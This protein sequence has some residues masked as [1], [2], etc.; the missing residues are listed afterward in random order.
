MKLI[1]QFGQ[2]LRYTVRGMR[3]N[4]LFTAMAV[5]SLA[6]G[7][8]ANTAIYSFMEAILLR[9]LPVGDPHR[10]VVFNWRSKDFPPVAHS[11]S[12]NNHKEP[13]TGMISN[14]LP[15]PAFDVLR[16]GGMCSPVFAFTNGG[17]LNVQVG[18]RAELGTTQFV[19]GEFFRG[20]Q[21]AP[22]A[23]R[24]LEESDDRTGALLA[25][26]SHAFAVKI[27]GSA[28]KAPGQ[29]IEINKRPVTVAGVAPPEFFGVNAAGAQD[30]YMPIHSMGMLQGSLNPNYNARFTDPNRFWVQMMGRLK[31]DVSITQ[32]QAALAGGF[33]AMVDAAAKTPKEKADLPELLVVEGATGLDQLRYRYSKPLYLLMTLVGFILAIACANTANLLLARSTARRKEMA[34]R[35]SLGAGRSRVMRQMLT[36]SVLLSLAGAALGLGIAAW[37]IELLTM[38]IGGGKT[39]FTLHAELNWNVLAATLALSIMTGVLFGLAPALQATRVDL[40]AS[41]KQAGLAERRRRFGAGQ[42]LAGA[43]IATSLLLLVAAGLFV[44]TLAN[45]N[46]IQLGFNR[47]HLLTFS[48]NARQAG[49]QGDTQARFYDTLR[50][51]LA[52]IPGVRAVTASSMVLATGSLS[53][54]GLNVPGAPQAAKGTTANIDVGA[55]FFGTMEIPI[56][57]GR[58]IEE[59]D[60]TSARKVAV[61]NEVFVKQFLGEGNPLGRRFGLGDSKA[62]PDIEIVGVSKGVT[63]QSLKLEIPPVVYVPYGQNPASLFGLNFEVRSAGPPLAIAEAVRKVVRDMDSRIP[64]AD[65]DTQARLIDGTTSQERTFAALGSGLAMLAVLIACVGLYGTMSYSVAR[66]TAEIGV[67]MAL[68]AQRARVVRMVLRDVV[69]VAG[70]GLAVGL[71]VAWGAA[72]MVESFLFGVKAKDPAVLITAPVVL[73]LAAVAAGYGPA[74]RASRID[75]WTALRSD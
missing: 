51:K 50:S 29:T 53:N 3:N 27:F 13:D 4:R 28:E 65:I 36:E 68:G 49:Y 58:D 11:F 21:L 48:L 43:Q 45:L 23:G 34:V 52:A 14:T 42:V 8:G 20:L 61:V 19:S 62:T 39:N 57:L 32:A 64:V 2:D 71:P 73:F 18:G 33:H 38:L 24:L 40:A 70:V 12:G 41:L 74:W 10:L 25:V 44:R 37:G 31:P 35:L 16:A 47:E 9:S 6:L 7:I 55:S 5:V 26:M 22:A 63:H 15:Y 60:H 1:E 66:R 75:P 67:R 72:R 54:T 59:R 30:L 17:R 69:L 56:L 46:A